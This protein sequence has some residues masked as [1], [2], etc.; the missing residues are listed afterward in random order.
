MITLNDEDE[1]SADSEVLKQM[2]KYTN[3]D[4]LIWTGCEI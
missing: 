3:R 2:T 1:F 4:K